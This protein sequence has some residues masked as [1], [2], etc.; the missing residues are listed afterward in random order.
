MCQVT[1]FASTVHLTHHCVD[2]GEKLLYTHYTKSS[3]QAKRGA[4]L[5]LS[6]ELWNKPK[7]P[8]E[9]EIALICHA[10]IKLRPELQ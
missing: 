1:T 9:S 5:L 6:H 3:H 2:Y 8:S 7:L 4:L 10:H